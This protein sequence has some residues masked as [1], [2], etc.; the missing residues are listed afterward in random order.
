[1]KKSVGKGRERNLSSLGEPV[2]N[3][4]KEVKEYGINV[5]FAAFLIVLRPPFTHGPNQR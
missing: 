4:G 2:V 5:G 1:M 3:K